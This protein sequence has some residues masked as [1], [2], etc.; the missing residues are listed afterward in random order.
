M[1]ALCMGIFAMAIGAAPHL[2]MN[3]IVHRIAVGL[4][5]PRL[6]SLGGP[7][8]RPLF[9]KRAMGLLVGL[10]ARAARMP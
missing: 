5:A 2:V 6:A 7:G 3:D 4:V 1:Q 9:V 8:G 10:S